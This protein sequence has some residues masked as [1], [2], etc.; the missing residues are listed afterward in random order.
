MILGKLS[1]SYKNAK[2]IYYI[3]NIIFFQMGCI[4]V[5]NPSTMI[6]S[7]ILN[8][9]SELNHIKIH[10]ANTI[11]PNESPENNNNLSIHNN[12]LPKLGKE[13]E[14]N[15]KQLEIEDSKPHRQS[16]GNIGERTEVFSTTKLPPQESIN[17]MKKINDFEIT[18]YDK[19]T[20]KKALLSHFLF[21]DKA[22]QIMYVFDMIII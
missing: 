1:F 7:N 20:I 15:N 6:K 14:N 4:Q 11:K 3:V 19:L 9:E 8:K 5:S 16:L 21:K 17:Q 12:S 18:E 13:I 2:Y 22:L 10:Q